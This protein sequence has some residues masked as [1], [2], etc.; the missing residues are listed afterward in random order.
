M[1][2]NK[3]LKDLC[4]YYPTKRYWN[5]KKIILAQFTTCVNNHH[6]CF[7]RAA[8]TKEVYNICTCCDVQSIVC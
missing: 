8:N 7:Y 4:N 2:S 3:I 1:L 5:L 6:L